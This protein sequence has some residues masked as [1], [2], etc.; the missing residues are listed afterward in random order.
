MVTHLNASCD[1]NSVR[2]CDDANMSLSTAR[3]LRTNLLRPSDSTSASERAHRVSFIELFFDLVF[4]FA[5]TQLSDVVADVDSPQSATVALV[6]VLAVWWLWMNTT[7]ATN[8]VDPHFLAVRGAIIVLAFAGIVVSVSLQ[9]ADGARALAFAIAYVSLQLG[10]SLAM[11]A[12]TAR[13]D[14]VAANDFRRMSVWFAVSGVAWVAGA[15]VGGTALVVLWVVA[16]TID[17][18]GAGLSYRT[19]RLGRGDIAQWDLSAAH[20]AERASLFVII[21]LGETFLVTGFAFVA[22]ELTLAN[23]LA[24]VSAF[25]SAAAMWWFYF[26]HGEWWGERRLEKVSSPGAIARSAY[27]Y[28]HVVIIGGIILVGVADKLVVGEP[29]SWSTITL[30]SIVG[31]PAVYLIGCAIFRRIVGAPGVLVAIIAA[32]GMLALTPLALITSPIIVSLSATA[33]LIAAAATDTVLRLRRG[34]DSRG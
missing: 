13:H 15:L 17:L 18:L 22:E 6:V 31:G 30:V 9:E 25:L 12:A 29:Q 1:I 7:W 24:L 2:L 5:L 8:W 32:I 3:G 21:A 26:D 33:V 11:V 27:A 10:R 19:P 14:A 28:A 34:D 23:A 16:I 20:I 4:V